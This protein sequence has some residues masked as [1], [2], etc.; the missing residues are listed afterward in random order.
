M[1][2]TCAGEFKAETPYFYSTYD[3]ENEAA[4]FIEHQNTGKKKV[5]VLNLPAPSSLNHPFRLIIP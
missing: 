2:D 4:E 3:E 1:V 5:L